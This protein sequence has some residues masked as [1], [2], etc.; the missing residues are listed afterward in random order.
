[1]HR[2]FRRPTLIVAIA[3]LV[4]LSAA[5]CASRPASGGGGG[6]S[7]ASVTLLAL[8]NAQRNAAGLPGLLWCPPL[9]RS[10]QG[11]AD[12]QAIHNTMTH[13]GTDNSTL[14]QRVERAGYHGWSAISENVA[15]QWPSAD[16][17]M[18]G[19]MNSPEHRANILS[20]D[21]TYFGGGVGWSANGTTYWTQDFGRGG[22][23]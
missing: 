9:E 11:H 22:G 16:A 1:M 5:G 13:V 21:F 12:D 8:V 4:V 10:A 19:W 17:V 14:A 18:V 3:A 6:A 2:L 23:C 7:P 15:A 20:P